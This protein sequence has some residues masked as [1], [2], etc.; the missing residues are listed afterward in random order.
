LK[1]ILADLLAKLLNSYKS[2][3]YYKQNHTPPIQ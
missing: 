1:A 2:L 3:K